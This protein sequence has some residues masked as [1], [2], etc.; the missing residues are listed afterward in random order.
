[1]ETGA[2]GQGG[3]S[4]SP[5]AVAVG[6]AVLLLAFAALALWALGTPDPVVP[7]GPPPLVAVKTSRPP[8]A[9]PVTPPRPSDPPAPVPATTFPKGQL[10]TPRELGPLLAQKF[11]FTSRDGKQAFAQLKSALGSER[12]VTVLNVWAPYCEPCKREFPAFRRLQ[13]GW[14]DAV[15]FLPIQ[16]GEGDP[17]EFAEMMPVAPHHLIDYVPGGAV[18]QTLTS[19]GLLSDKAPIPITLVLDC[20]HQLRW[21]QAEEVKD[22]EAFERTIEELRRELDTPACRAPPQASEPAAAKA[23]GNGV[24]EPLAHD[25]DCMTC[26]TDCRCKKDQLC[27]TQLGAGR[28]GHVCMDELQ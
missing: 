11:Q 24:C 9:E 21:L 4:L 23:C 5:R 2:E 10:E 27:A 17:S 12:A 22:M 7:P 25:E 8:P 1:M 26:P 28:H 20:R 16:L 6:G 14:G 3:S 15:R 19:M 18:Q 13:S